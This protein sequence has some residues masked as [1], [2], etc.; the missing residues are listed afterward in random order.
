M[1]V[2]DGPCTFSIGDHKATIYDFTCD[3]CEAGVPR[4]LDCV[5]DDTSA[6][7]LTCKWTGDGLNVAAEG[8]AAQAVFDYLGSSDLRGQFDCI[9]GGSIPTSGYSGEDICAL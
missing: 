9:Q 5:N 6:P 7:P 2:L 8:N 4:D 1:P 3:P